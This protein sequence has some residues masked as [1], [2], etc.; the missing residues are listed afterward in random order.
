MTWF[1][2]NDLLKEKWK[3]LSNFL[4]V[5]VYKNIKQKETEALTRFP[6][7]SIN[8]L[9]LIYKALANTVLYI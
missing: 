9:E 1:S 3:H 5:C 8:G 7:G 4:H 2:I 6:R